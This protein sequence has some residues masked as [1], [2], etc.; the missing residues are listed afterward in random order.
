MAQLLDLFCKFFRAVLEALSGIMGGNLV[1][2][3]VVAAY[4]KP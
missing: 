2:A 3:D 1:E 4:G